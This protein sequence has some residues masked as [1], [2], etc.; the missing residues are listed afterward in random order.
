MMNSSLFT[1]ACRA[2]AALTVVMSL[3]A[4]SSTPAEKDE[5]QGWWIG[6]RV[7][8]SPRISIDLNRQVVN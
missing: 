7:Q 5:A 4:C 1:Q 2:A 3:G 8:G 6:D